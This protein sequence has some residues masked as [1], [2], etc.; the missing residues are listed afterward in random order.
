MAQLG[1]SD[2]SRT[3]IHMLE[4][5]ISRPS[6]QVLKLIALRTGKSVRYFQSAGSDGRLKKQMLAADLVSLAG[7]VKRIRETTKLDLA[8]QQSLKLLESCLRQGAVLVRNV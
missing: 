1:G 7:R 5:G 4:K 8:L 6:P 2:I 3:F